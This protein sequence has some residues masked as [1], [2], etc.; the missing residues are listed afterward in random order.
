MRLFFV[1]KQYSVRRDFIADRYFRL[2]HFPAELARRG[3]QVLGFASAYRAG[4]A[5]GATERFPG[6]GELAWEAAR[7]RPAWPFDWLGALR[8]Q[9]SRARVAGVQ[10]VVA[11]SDALQLACGRRLARALGVPLFVDFYDN[12]ESYGAS[13]APGARR[14][15]ATAARAAAGTLFVSEPLRQHLVARYGLRA[16]TITLEN[17]VD[18]HAFAA[19]TREDARRELGLPPDARIV[20]TAGAL[21]AS[22]GIDALYGAFL[23]LARERDDVFL[24]L[25]GDARV[26]P[27]AHPRVRHLGTL[28][29]ARMPLFWR[30]LD[31]AAICLRDDAFGRY[32]YPQKLPEIAAVGTPMVFPRIGVF[33]EPDAGRL[34]VVAPTADPAG[35]AAAIRQQLAAPMP[36]RRRPQSWAELGARLEAFLADTLALSR[37]A[38]VA[39]G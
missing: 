3:H 35:F 39:R 11:S 30:A 36:P 8:R 29:Q 2:W 6:G 12:Y 17:G 20:G 31:V 15:I 4:N 25:A 24:A 22:R 5:A 21:D 28:G 38:P 13:R 34:G 37:T 32:C 33:A 18:P 14:A 19:G 23:Q 26:A 10:A 1:T 27:P 7:L 16:P 9:R